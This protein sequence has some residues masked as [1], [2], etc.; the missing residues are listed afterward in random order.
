MSCAV[1]G[2]YS[3]TLSDEGVVH[4]F[5]R[6]E[7]GQ[8]GL[9]H[10]NQVLVPTP[11]QNLPF[12]KQ[13]SCGFHFTLC[14]DRDGCVWSFGNNSNGQLGLGTISNCYN[15]PQKV[16]DLPPVQSIACGYAH[17]LL[18]TNNETFF[19]CGRNDFG[20]L[21]CRDTT[22]NSTFLQTSFT[23]VLRISAGGLF[24]LFQTDDGVYGCGYNHHG[25]LG[26]GNTCYFQLEICKVLNL[27]PNIIQFCC[28]Y[29]HSIFLDDEGKVYSVGIN[30]EGN[31]GLGHKN[32]TDIIEQIPN[33]PPIH[34]IACVANS[35]Y[36]LDFDGNVWSFGSNNFGQLGLPADVNNDNKISDCNVPTKIPSLKDIK[37]ISN[38][39]SGEHFFAKD[40]QNKIFV[41]GN[42]C[43]GQLGTGNTVSSAIPT[44]IYSDCLLSQNIWGDSLKSRAKSARK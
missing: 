6:N 13:V 27:P 16:N 2:N 18:L 44:E 28:G 43:Y 19:S 32:N 17:A 12:I 39:Y 40:C 21:C 15:F 22:D 5:G 3:I 7:H 8:L 29:Y 24:T 41:T 23:N 1:G 25:Q 42:N 33:I 26:L 11:I 36:L 4:S 35:N 37:Q 9:T 10:N 20:Q 31:L 30:I 38:G 14:V 34:I